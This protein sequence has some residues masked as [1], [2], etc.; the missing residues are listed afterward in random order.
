MK[1]TAFRPRATLNAAHGFIFAPAGFG[2]EGGHV[3]RA[4]GLHQIQIKFFSQN[5]GNN[6]DKLP[7]VC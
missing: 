4:F 6:I 1:L 5:R 2:F 3:K 7:V